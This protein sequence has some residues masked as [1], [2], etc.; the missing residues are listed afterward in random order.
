MTNLTVPAEE[1]RH[2][3]RRDGGHSVENGRHRLSPSGRRQRFSTYLVG[4]LKERL[5][6]VLMERCDHLSRRD[7]R[8]PP[9]IFANLFDD[10]RCKERQRPWSCS[11]ASEGE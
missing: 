7:E 1:D 8:S 2:T 5:R 4:S 6:K 9:P 3:G 11:R 10:C